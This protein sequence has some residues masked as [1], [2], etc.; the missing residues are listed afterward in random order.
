MVRVE[1][2]TAEQMEERLGQLVELLQDAVESGASVGFLPPVGAEEGRAYW[3]TVREAIS[4]GGRVLLAAADGNRIVGTVQLD[5]AAMSNARHRAEVMKLMVHRRARRRGI[6]RALMA[7]LEEEARLA[8]RRLLVLDTRAGD[9][10]E[11][12]YVSLGYTRA[13]VIPRYARS[14]AGSLDDTVY[15]YRE[16]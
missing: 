5:L 8:G 16:L 10:A 15:Y 3:R 12:L 11:Q 6:G 14:A 4:G 9:A 1:R 2:L 13:G 7:G